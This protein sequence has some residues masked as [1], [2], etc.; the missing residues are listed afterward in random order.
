MTIIYEDDQP[1]AL[2]AT[3]EEVIQFFRD[4]DRLSDCISSNARAIM[5][6]ILKQ[7]HNERKSNNA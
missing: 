2:I 6:E 3:D 1:Y 7:E 4:H 5:L